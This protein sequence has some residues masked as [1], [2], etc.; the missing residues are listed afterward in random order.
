MEQKVKTL[1]FNGSVLI[2]THNYFHMSFDEYI[3]RKLTEQEARELEIDS[4]LEDVYDTDKMTYIRNMQEALGEEDK[5]I[6][7]MLEI[8]EDYTI[9]ILEQRYIDKCD[10][11]DDYE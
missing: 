9:E 10:T 2:I 1:P 4:F 3:D 5:E 11:Y 6:D 8:G 7:E